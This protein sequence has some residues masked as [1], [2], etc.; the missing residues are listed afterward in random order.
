MISFCPDV[1]RCG[2]AS[3]RFLLLVAKSLLPPC[4]ECASIPGNRSCKLSSFK[5]KTSRSFLF[6]EVSPGFTVST[7][8][9]SGLK[10]SFFEP[11]KVWP[12]V[13]GVFS[14]R[15]DCRSFELFEK[16]ECEFS[17]ISASKL[18]ILLLYGPRSECFVYKFLP[19]T[20]RPELC[21][22]RSF[23]FWIQ[24]TFDRRT[25]FAFLCSSTGFKLE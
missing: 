6:S 21:S 19:G 20:L 24:P 18:S 7:Q 8:L 9:C 25:L 23:D 2:S 14:V 4:G 10:P 3:H 12:L 11:P 16:K 22:R 5:L 1:S 17:L 15:C 13:N